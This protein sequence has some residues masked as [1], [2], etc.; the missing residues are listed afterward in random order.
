MIGEQEL[1]NKFAEWAGVSYKNFTRSIDACF[2][3]LVPKAIGL[4]ADTDLS[5]T[6]EATHKLFDMWLQE[7]AK[8]PYK[9][10][11]GARTLC[12][13]VEKLIDAEEALE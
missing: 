4:L 2:G 8:S 11:Y 12:L 7:I 13:A 6:M 5:T 1:N 10:D 3:W 9:V